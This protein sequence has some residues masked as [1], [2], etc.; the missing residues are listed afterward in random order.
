MNFSQRIL[1]ITAVVA[2]LSLSLFGCQPKDEEPSASS[3]YYDGEMKGK[4]A[5][6]G[7]AGGDDPTQAQVTAPPAGGGGAGASAGS[8]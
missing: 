6:G 8:E 3:G 7:A 4:G 1:L 2:G 5:P